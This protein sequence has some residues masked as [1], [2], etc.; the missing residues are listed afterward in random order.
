MELFYNYHPIEFDI[1]YKYYNEEYTKVNKMND[2]ELVDYILTKKIVLDNYKNRSRVIKLYFKSL[3]QNEFISK[4]KEIDQILSNYI[5]K[6]LE[7]EKVEYRIDTVLSFQCF[8]CDENNLPINDLEQIPYTDNVVL[9]LED[10]YQHDYDDDEENLM[11]HKSK[12]LKSPNWLTIMFELYL[13]LYKMEKRLD[14]SIPEEGVS[15]MSPHKKLS[16]IFTIINEIKDD[17][18]YVKLIV[19]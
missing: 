13:M 2:K 9:E 15:A 7:E 12:V 8:D 6:R 16:L 11:V 4:S 18:K 17:I 10:I 3:Y 5:D 19:N 1:I 14:E